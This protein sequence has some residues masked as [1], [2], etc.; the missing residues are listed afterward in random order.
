MQQM[1]VAHT[2]N[3]SITSPTVAASITL[4]CKVRGGGWEREGEG[5]EGEEREEE[6]REEVGRRES[7]FHSST[8]GWINK[9]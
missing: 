3:V 6:G 5:R 1:G 7:D 9:W 8:Q 2:G 4:T